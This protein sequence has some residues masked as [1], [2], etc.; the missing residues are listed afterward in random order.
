VSHDD[1]RDDAKGE[2]FDVRKTR[3]RDAEH[4]CYAARRVGAD[5]CAK[6]FFHA[7]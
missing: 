5:Y 6:S 2:K 3:L 1:E 4:D 7:G